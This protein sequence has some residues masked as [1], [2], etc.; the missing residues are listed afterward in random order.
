MRLPTCGR[1]PTLAAPLGPRAS[2]NAGA[3][4]ATAAAAE[5]VAVAMLLFVPV[6]ALPSTAPEAC[7]GLRGAVR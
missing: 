6:R 3:A 5:A 2:A 7:V 4:A 1:P